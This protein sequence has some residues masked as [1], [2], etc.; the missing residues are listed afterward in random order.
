MILGHPPLFFQGFLIQERLNPLASMGYLLGLAWPKL[1][2][3][4]LAHGHTL[5]VT[6]TQVALDY[7]VIRRQPDSPVRAGRY[8]HLAIITCLG[9][10]RHPP[11]GLIRLQGVYGQAGTQGGLAQL[12]HTRG[13]RIPSIK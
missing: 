8:A 9:I 13:T 6:P 5:R 10:Q 4:G 1:N 7:I 12:M 11:C 2:S 3:L